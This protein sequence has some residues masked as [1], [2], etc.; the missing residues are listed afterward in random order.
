MIYIINVIIKSLSFY[1]LGRVCVPIPPETCDNF[2]PLNV[3]TIKSLIEELDR[4]GNNIE[5]KIHNGD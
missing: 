2:N 1:L 4:P 3:P 5:G